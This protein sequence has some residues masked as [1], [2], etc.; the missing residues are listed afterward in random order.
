MPNITCGQGNGGITAH[1]AAFNRPADIARAVDHAAAEVVI[2][3]VE[4]VVVPVH[5]GVQIVGA[6]APELTCVA[7]GRRFP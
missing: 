1:V 4:C 2:D 6:H 7:D 5:V 3:P